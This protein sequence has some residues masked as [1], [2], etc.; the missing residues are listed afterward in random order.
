MTVITRIIKVMGYSFNN[1]LAILWRS[2][3]LLEAPHVVL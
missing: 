2:V 3:L 1:S